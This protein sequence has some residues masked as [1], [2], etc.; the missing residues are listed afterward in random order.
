VVDTALAVAGAVRMHDLVGPRDTA[1][2]TTWRTAIGWPPVFRV[3]TRSTTTW[4]TGRRHCTRARTEPT[5][6]HW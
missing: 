3:S 6:E 4:R 2:S 5:N 1:D